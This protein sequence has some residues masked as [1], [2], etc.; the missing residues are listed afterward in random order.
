ML[1]LG[2]NQ[3]LFFGRAASESVAAFL[4]LFSGCL[5]KPD[6]F[7]SECICASE[8]DFQLQN[9]HSKTGRECLSESDV[10][11]C[12]LSH[13]TSYKSTHTAPTAICLSLKDSRLLCQ[14]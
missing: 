9:L 2:S 12:H 5:E 8:R 3:Q 11:F 14:N 6:L 4:L 1:H 10:L 13:V 7:F